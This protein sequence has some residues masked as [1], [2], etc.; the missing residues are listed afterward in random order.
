MLVFLQ[1]SESES[2]G[3]AVRGDDEPEHPGLLLSR[4]ACRKWNCQNKKKAKR[5]L[6]KHLLALPWYHSALLIRGIDGKR[7]CKSSS[8]LRHAAEL[9]EALPLGGV[10]RASSGAICNLLIA[11]IAVCRLLLR[12]A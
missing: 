6:G 2:G 10:I 3:L 1:N 4:F 11:T 8:C 7:C 12:Q 5:Q 9:R